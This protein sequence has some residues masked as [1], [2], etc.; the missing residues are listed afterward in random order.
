M[1]T[2][3]PPTPSVHQ[4]PS[5][6][7]P[8]RSLYPASLLFGQQREPCPWSKATASSPLPTCQVLLAIL[9]GEEKEGR[10]GQQPACRI[11]HLP[12]C[13]SV[14]TFT[15]VSQLCFTSSKP[16]LP[17][18]VPTEWRSIRATTEVQ[19]VSS[20][21][22]VHRDREVTHFHTYSR[23][24]LSSVVQKESQKWF[25]A[26]CVTLLTFIK[27]HSLSVPWK[28]LCERW[29]SQHDYI[30]HCF[31]IVIS[32]HVCWKK[33]KMQFVVLAKC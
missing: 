31:A 20:S 26:E 32:R 24:S 1:N 12:A 9:M 3:R 22:A 10:G 2:N 30:K 4:P 27:S 13:L 23:S 19:L 18:G 33:W 17:A 28:L 25:F 5:A 8:L 7:N 14:P 6:T 29:E 11:Q 21:L 16:R 15:A